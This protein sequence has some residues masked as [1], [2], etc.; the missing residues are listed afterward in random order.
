MLFTGFKNRDLRKRGGFLFGGVVQ[1]SNNLILNVGLLMVWLFEKQDHNIIVSSLSSISRNTMAMRFLSISEVRCLT[2]NFATQWEVT[3][4]QSLL[5]HPQI[6][7]VL[8]VPKEKRKFTQQSIVAV[9]VTLPAAL[10]TAGLVL[11][12]NHS[13]PPDWLKT[14]FLGFFLVI[15]FFVWFLLHFVVLYRLTT[16]GTANP[17][18]LHGTETLGVK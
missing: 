10:R 11:I 16:D 12:Y 5:C 15:N 1:I 3:S 14:T 18:I 8:S 6:D 7:I 13:T 17:L 2:R 4:A 9:L